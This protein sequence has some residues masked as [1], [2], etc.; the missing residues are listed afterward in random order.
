M[1]RRLRDPLQ[2]TLAPRLIQGELTKQEIAFEVSGDEHGAPRDGDILLAAANVVAMVNS[3]FWNGCE[4]H[5]KDTKSRTKW[6]AT[7]IAENQQRDQL[8]Q[9]FIG[10]GIDPATAANQAIAA[11]DR[12]VRREA[13]VMAYNDA[14]WIV[15]AILLS[16]ILVL[17][18]ADKVKSPSGAGGGGGGH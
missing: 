18:F 6:W 3:C 4:E 15:G 9:A 12:I 7:R 17:W 1:A 8:T 11:V 13:Y 5:T 10:H 14:F 2:D 16:A